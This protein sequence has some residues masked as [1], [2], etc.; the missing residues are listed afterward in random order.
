MDGHN[1][2]LNHSECSVACHMDGH[3]AALNHSECSVACH[4]DGHSA[5]LNHSECSVV[6]L[7]TVQPSRGII[8]CGQTSP[9]TNH[10][11]IL[12]SMDRQNAELATHLPI[13]Y[14]GLQQ[15]VFL[16]QPVSSAGVN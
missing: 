13:G 2:M 3:N 10:L 1:A 9:E 8:V 15:Q 16:G 14:G 11:E 6:V 5:V 7:L 4:M 12:P